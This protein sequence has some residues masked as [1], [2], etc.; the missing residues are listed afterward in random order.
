MPND[1]GDVSYVSKLSDVLN[2]SIGVFDGNILLKL[3]PPKMAI[4]VHG[5]VQIVAFHGGV[6]YNARRQRYR[7]KD[8]AWIEDKTLP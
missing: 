7:E 5:P 2:V 4:T 8:I 3:D 1:I 6:Y